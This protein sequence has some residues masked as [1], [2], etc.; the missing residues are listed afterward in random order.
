MSWLDDYFAD[1]LKDRK[2]REIEY[3]NIDD[4]YINIMFSDGRL[5]TLSTE[6]DC[7]AHHYLTTDD[8]CQY[9]TTSGAVLV[10]IELMELDTVS[11]EYG[12]EHETMF[13]KIQT[14]KGVVTVVAHNEHNGYYGGFRVISS[15]SAGVKNRYDA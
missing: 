8:D 6:S 2:L 11:E 10:G 15:L 13:V 9:V 12:G 1:H 3:I 7:C 14:S 5:W 4:K